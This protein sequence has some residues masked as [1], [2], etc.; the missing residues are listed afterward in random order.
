M[1]QALIGA[2]EPGWAKIS[3][4]NGLPNRSTPATSVSAISQTTSWRSIR[5]KLRRSRWT[6]G[7]AGAR[8]RRLAPHPRERG[9]GQLDMPK[10]VADPQR[11]VGDLHVGKR[12]HQPEGDEDGEVK[13]QNVDERGNWML[14][15]EVDRDQHHQDDEEAAVEPDAVIPSLDRV[16]DRKAPGRPLRHRATRTVPVRSIRWSAPSK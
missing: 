15:S 6:A 12:P 11:V 13:Q 10:E 3:R 1:P 2:A 14:L 4:K 9:V 7:E 16:A 5:H 8:P